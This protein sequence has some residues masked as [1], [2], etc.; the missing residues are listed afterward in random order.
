VG[1]FDP[2]VTQRTEPL[3]DAVDIGLR[4]QLSALGLAHEPHRRQRDGDGLDLTALIDYASDRRTGRA[5]DPRVYELRRTTGHDLGVLILLDASGS[6]GESTAGHQIFAGERQLAARLTAEL[7]ALGNRVATY[8][9]YSRG[10]DNVRFLRVKT[11]DEPYDFTARRRMAAIEPTG[12]T[13]LGA[14]VR[15]AAHVLREHAGTS[16]LLLIVIGDGLPYEDGYEHR[17]A[18]EDTRRALAE[19][20]G[21]GVGCACVAMRSPTAPEVIDRVWG[22]VAH[23]WLEHPDE[24]ARQVRPLLHRA[25]RDAA[26]QP[27]APTDRKVAA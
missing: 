18:H 16:R 12:F 2:P 15:H 14:A 25:L 13:R 24:L 26:S 27:G 20:V 9:F 3:P 17:H 22:H 19:A 21:T 1:Q 6:T 11:F 23:C 10:K 4:R 7:D 5:G 8:G